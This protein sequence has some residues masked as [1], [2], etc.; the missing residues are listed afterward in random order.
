[1]NRVDILQASAWA[2]KKLIRFDKGY[3]IKQ[4]LGKRFVGGVSQNNILSFT[5]LAFHAFKLI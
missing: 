5:Y 4:H 1:M 3:I 2:S